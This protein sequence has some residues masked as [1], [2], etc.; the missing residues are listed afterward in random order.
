MTDEEKKERARI[1]SKKYYETHKQLK[2]K[3]EYCVY[4]YINIYTMEVIYVGSS[5]RINIRKY[6]REKNSSSYSTCKFDRIYKNLPNKEDIAFEIVEY[7][8]D[9]ESAFEREKDLIR[10]IQPKYNVLKYKG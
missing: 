9:K 4:Q 5:K 7:F 1:Y 2:N 6:D 3:E 8:S 10:E